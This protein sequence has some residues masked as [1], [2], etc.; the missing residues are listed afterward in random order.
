MSGE[1]GNKRQKL[2]EIDEETLNSGAEGYESGSF[3]FYE[4]ESLVECI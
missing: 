2:V 1:N 4:K 3:L